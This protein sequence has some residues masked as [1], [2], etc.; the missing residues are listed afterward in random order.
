MTVKLYP[1]ATLMQ[2]TGSV[3][4]SPVLPAP[5]STQTLIN[6]RDSTSRAYT[7]GTWTTA[8]SYTVTAGK[9]LYITDFFASILGSTGSGVNSWF[10]QLYNG[11]VPIA[12]GLINGTNG[13]SA[14]N[15]LCWFYIAVNSPL[16]VSAATT[17]SI[18]IAPTSNN[19]TVAILTGFSGVEQ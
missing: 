6:Q 5:A 3:T 2:V 15:Q 4:A 13:T 8:L 7:T 18:R 10:I 16:S 1:I 9:T 12:E 11:T 17:V 14:T 19:E